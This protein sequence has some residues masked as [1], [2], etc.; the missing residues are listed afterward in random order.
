MKPSSVILEEPHV[1]GFAVHQPTTTNVDE[2]ATLSASV[3]LN[4]RAASVV[5]W[6]RRHGTPYRR[7]IPVLTSL[8]LGQLGA[9]EGELAMAF[10]GQMT[11]SELYDV[12]KHLAT[13]LGL[14]VLWPTSD[15]LVVVLTKR[16][17]IATKP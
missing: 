14:V 15:G 17:E 2:A 7:Q 8:P 13:A 5:L 4:A 3:L 11:H 16:G 9:H 10:E 12:L 1:A 6:L